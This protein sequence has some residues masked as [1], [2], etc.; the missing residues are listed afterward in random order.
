MRKILLAVILSL[1][2]VSA[3]AVEMQVY[4]GYD[5]SG[6]YIVN[7]NL[8]DGGSKYLKN[9]DR[10]YL[11][12]TLYVGT[13]FLI[14]PKVTLNLRSYILY[15]SV[16][17]SGDDGGPDSGQVYL[18]RYWIGYKPVENLN[19][20]IG[21][22]T[23][24]NYTVGFASGMYDGSFS[25]MGGK[26]QIKATFDAND[27]MTVYGVYTKNFESSTQA[28]GA[29]D[30]GVNINGRDIWSFLAGAKINAND[31]FFNPYI[32]YY[33][34]HDTSGGYLKAGKLYSVYAEAGMQPETGLNWIVALGYSQSAGDK[35]ATIP[36][37]YAVY[38]AYLDVSMVDAA[39]KVGGLLAYASYDKK[40]GYFEFG[41]DFDKTIIM[42]R[43]FGYNVPDRNAPYYD[44]YGVPASTMLQIY[45]GFD[46]TP[47]FYLDLSGSYYMSNVDNKDNPADFYDAKIGKDTTAYEIDAILSYTFTESTTFSVGAAYAQINDLL[48]PDRGFAEKYSPDAIMKV[49]WAASTS[50]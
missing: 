4:G 49:Y 40:K 5:V 2:V 7:N 21:R 8:G 24:N 42:D 41:G 28:V 20:E 10:A 17:G 31:L 35:D 34:N 30:N 44:D 19:V 18:D 3:Y 33:F 1:F 9:Q 37:D 16:M 32:S 13:R 38:G 14:D 48:N 29:P 6:N 22:I 25:E 11:E 39:F 26:N 43:S 15:Q 27:D 12:H 46:L 36:K 45:A 23:G 50:F 47:E